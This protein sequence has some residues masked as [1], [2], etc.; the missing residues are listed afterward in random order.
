[1]RWI[2]RKVSFTHLLSGN[3]M[4]VVRTAQRFTAACKKTG[5]LANSEAWSR[6]LWA[7]ADLQTYHLGE[8]LQGFLFAVE[9]RDMLNW[10]AVIEASV[11]LVMT[12]QSMLRFQ[13]V[14]DEMQQLIEF[15]LDTG[16]PQYIVVAQSCQARLSLL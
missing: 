15:A 7:N 4:A 1:M 2:R 12:H 16:E 14:V 9:R 5:E 6:Y 10:K 3:L 11:G 8:A 13:D